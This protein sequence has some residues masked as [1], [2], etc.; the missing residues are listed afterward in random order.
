MRLLISWV[1][2]FVDVTASGEEIAD[3]RHEVREAASRL[4][5]LTG[6]D[7]AMT[8]LPE[9]TFARIDAVRLAQVLDN[10]L[11]NAAKYSPEGSPIEVDIS[12][13]GPALRVT[14]RDTGTGIGPDELDHLF[15]RGFRSP[16][17]ADIAGEGLGLA[18]CKQIVEAQG[19]RIWAE[20]AGPDR[21]SAFHFELPEAV[22]VDARG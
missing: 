2:D 14:V 19:G 20:S 8:A 3:V 18:V 4:R 21:G 5:T 10:L 13:S 22:P 7:A 9:P 6:R 11:R 17:H 1:R 16:R 12:R 15:D